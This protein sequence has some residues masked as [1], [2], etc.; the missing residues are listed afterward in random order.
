MVPA[1]SCRCDVSVVVVAF[2]E[3]EK[4]LEALG[5]ARAALDRL[6]AGG[7]LIVV[8]NGGLAGLVRE[9]FPDA[10]VIG[11]GANIGFAGAVDLGIARARGR[12]IAL[13][14]DDARIEADA[15]SA[16]V[17]AGDG[18]P[19]VGAVAGQVRFASTPGVINSAG[20]AID[21]LGV[22]TE[23]LAGRPVAAA[24][25]GIEVFGPTACFA[26][27]RREMLDAIGP[28]EARFFAYLEDVDLA[29]RA[30][31]AGWRSIYEPAA[32]AYHHA[33]ASSGEGSRLKYYLSG[34]NRVWLLARNATDAQLA[35]ALP[36]ILLYDGAY[37][38][39]AALRDRTLAPLRGRVHG[40][41]RFRAMRDESAG[42]RAP[43]ALTPATRGWVES[44]RMHRSYRALGARAGDR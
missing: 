21:S 27:Y 18:D 28:L 42:R 12:W 17:A 32:V 31:A 22:A 29:W 37:I 15:L 33:S 34:R 1:V 2:R 23:R 19:G 44:W 7:E 40:L 5:A 24:A 41:R 20:I 39:Y 14:N 38:A 25:H 10:V 26:L 30:R 4:L 13:V 35:R 43:V 11:S 8:D 16:A 36:G 6:T 9:R 3:R